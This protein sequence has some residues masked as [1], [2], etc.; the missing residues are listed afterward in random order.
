MI[1]E[2]FLKKNSSSSDKELDLLYSLCL[3][4]N[5]SFEA[6]FFSQLFTR[7]ARWEPGKNADKVFLKSYEEAFNE[8]RV[9]GTI[10]VD[11]SIPFQILHMVVTHAKKGVEFFRALSFFYRA[12]ISQYEFELIEFQAKNSEVS[13]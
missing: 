4:G 11:F 8:V 7:V 13:S 6:E 10:P 1:S 2:K 5:D 12:M 3:N 9:R